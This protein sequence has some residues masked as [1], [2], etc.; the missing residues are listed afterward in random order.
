MPVGDVLG[1]A[2]DESFRGGLGPFDR[3]EVSVGFV[4]RCT[5]AYNVVLVCLCTPLMVG[6]FR[7][8]VVLTRL[9]L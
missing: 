7:L 5:L 2:L 3:P 6:I 4:G 9:A 1:D 8:M